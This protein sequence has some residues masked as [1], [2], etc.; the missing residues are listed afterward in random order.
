[1]TY[2]NF[3]KIVTERGWDIATLRCDNAP[4]TPELLD[5]MERF[6]LTRYENFTLRYEREL[7]KV[8]A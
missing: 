6:G 1:M 5:V 7:L 2:D 3:K 8:N 4:P